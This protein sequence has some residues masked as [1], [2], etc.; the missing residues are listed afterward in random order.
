MSGGGELLPVLLGNRQTPLG[1][2]SLC[3]LVIPV[4]TAAVI[5]DRRQ[6]RLKLSLGGFFG[7]SKPSLPVGCSSI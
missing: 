1:G 5:D 2:R 6:V 3:W 7:A 4:L